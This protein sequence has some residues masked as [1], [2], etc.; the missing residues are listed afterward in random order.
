VQALG[1][2]AS[3]TFFSNRSEGEDV[4]Q[5]RD[6]VTVGLSGNEFVC[7]VSPTRCVAHTA[8]K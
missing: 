5:L 1:Q 3:G 6:D 4:A 8:T 7:K 2:Q